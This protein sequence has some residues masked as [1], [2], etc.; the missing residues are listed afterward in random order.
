MPAGF[1]KVAR[2]GEIP[3][4]KSKKILL[5]DEEVALWRVDNH[6]YAVS[7]V[8]AHQHFS[9]LN[10]GILTGVHVTCPFHGWTYDLATG[11]STTG[12]G[13]VKTYRVVVEGDAVFVQTPEAE[14][15]GEA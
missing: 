8:C 4:R 14:S 10:K 7:N 9:S 11:C 1:V 5:G 15:E 13:R 3:D 6:F 2:V 12:N